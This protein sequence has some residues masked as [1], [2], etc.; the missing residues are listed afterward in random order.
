MKPRRIVFVASLLALSVFLGM[1]FYAQY[2]HIDLYV[3]RTAS[4]PTELSEKLHIEEHKIEPVVTIES[5]YENASDKVISIEEI[6]RIRSQIAWG[7]LMPPL[8]DSLTVQ[9][10]TRVLA[11]RVTSRLLIEYQLAKEGNRWVIKSAERGN[12]NRNAVENN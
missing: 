1:K 5:P 9:S 6:R 10:T 7:G 8:I 12:I 11:R 3:I 2:R 4:M